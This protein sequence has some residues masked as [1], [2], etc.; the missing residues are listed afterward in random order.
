MTAIEEAPVGTTITSVARNREPV[1]VPAYRYISPQFAALERERLWPRVWQLACTVDH[2][3]N[4]GDFY[5]YRSGRASAVIVRGDDGELRA[6]QNVCL[7]RGNELCSGSGTGLTEIRC[8]YHR[9]CWDLGGRLREVPSRREFGVL[10]DDYPLIDVQV[11]TWG[12]MVF[13]NLDRDA[14]P[15]AGPRREPRRALGAPAPHPHPRDRARDAHRLQ[16]GH[17]LHAGAEQ[18]E[19]RG[20]LA[21]QQ[22]RREPRHRGGADRGDGARVHDREQ[23]PVLDVEQ[24]HRADVR[25][26]ARPLVAGEDGHHL[27]PHRRGAPEVGGH[28]AERAPPVR[29][30]HDGAEREHR[31]PLGERPQGVRHHVHALRHRQER[32]DL[33]P[34]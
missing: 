8:S 27:E 18:G 34:R 6:F 31:V 21:R 4:A 5:E 15:L 33:A 23:P 11:G 2:V 10:N 9:W 1:T 22:P 16:V 25:V 14:E 29:Q 19:R 12:P 24:E 32:G 7:H 30:A 17:R 13:V 28:R 20:V 3:A 26:V